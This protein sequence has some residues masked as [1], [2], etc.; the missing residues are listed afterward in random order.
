[1]SPK[2]DVRGFSFPGILYWVVPRL[3]AGRQ[4]RGLDSLQAPR[5]DFDDIID[6]QNITGIDPKG[7]TWLSRKIKNFYKNNLQVQKK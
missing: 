7:S 6:F 3:P 4:W 2:R 1:M 5:D